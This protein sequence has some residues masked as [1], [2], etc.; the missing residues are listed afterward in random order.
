[1]PTDLPPDYKP[2]PVPAPGEPANPSPGAVPPTP[3][4]DSPG[5]P[6]GAPQPGPDVVVPT[7]GTVP[8]PAGLPTF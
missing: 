3:G 6:G 7:P 4:V 5:T 8:A 2:Q 1:M